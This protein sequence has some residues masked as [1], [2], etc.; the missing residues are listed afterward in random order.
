MARAMSTM[1][2]VM[3]RSSGSLA[4]SRTN[5]RSILSLSMGK[6]FRCARDECPVPKS[7]M[8]RRTPS[9]RSPSR[10]RMS[11]GVSSISMLSVSSNSRQAASSPVSASTR[12]TSSTR[13]FC[14]NC[15]ADRF[16]A[17]GIFGSP[18]ELPHAVL[19][20]GLAQDPGPDGHDEAA[21]LGDGDEVVGHHRRAFPLRPADERLD[22]HERAV[23]H[24]HLRL[25]VQLEG[26]LADRLPQAR[27][28]GERVEGRL[29]QALAEE[30]EVAA[31]TVLGEVHR[32]VG[33]ADERL[34]AG[35]VAREDRDAD[36]GAHREALPLE[37]R[38]AR[39]PPR[40]ASRPPGPGTARSPGPAGPRGTR[41]RPGARP[42]PRSAAT[43]RC[44]WR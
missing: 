4:M 31:A 37:R 41:R 43:P 10:V 9:R 40:G 26:L 6:R 32:R 15:T 34:G 27:L 39:S 19:A 17:T 24:A 38:R 42:R 30:L 2:A 29:R 8:A 5:V 18:D 3:A 1:A 33:V 36:R 44:A 21:L 35:A 14:L 28:E 25:V 12:S 7:S 16:T 13:F 11:S 20:A 22:A 23:V